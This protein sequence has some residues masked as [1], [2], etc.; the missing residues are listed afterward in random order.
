MFVGAFFEISKAEHTS[1]PILF[2]ELRIVM[3]GIL[4]FCNLIQ[5]CYYR[6][7]ESDLSQVTKL[8][9]GYLL[10]F[11]LHNSIFGME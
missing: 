9:L 2:F 1:D 10:A 5:Y 3:T 11:T 4:P 7:D 8:T 6:L